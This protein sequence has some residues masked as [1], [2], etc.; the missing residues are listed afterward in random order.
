MG[1]R[2]RRVCFCHVAIYGVDV[3]SVIG[4]IGLSGGSRQSGEEVYVISFL[5]LGVCGEFHD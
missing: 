5:S 2:Y 3:D 4:R 1:S